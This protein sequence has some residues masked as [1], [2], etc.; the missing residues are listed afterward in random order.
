MVNLDALNEQFRRLLQRTDTS[1]VRSSME[2]IQWEARLIGIKGARG[3][4]KTTLMLQRIQL[5]LKEEI[6]ATLYVSLDSL[7]FSGSTIW[8]IAEEFVGRGGKYLFLDEVHK[9]EN[10]AQELK[11]VYDH[12][13]EL[14]VVFTSSSLLEILSSRADLSRRAVVFEMQGLSLREFIQLESGVSFPMLTLKQIIEQ[15]ESIAP[16]VTKKIKPLHYFRSYLESGYY[17]FYFEQKDLY[18]QKVRE[19]VSMILEIELPQLRGVDLNYLARL[20]QLLMI[21]AESVPFAP[22]VTKLSERIQ[23]DRKTL[24]S[25]LHFFAE[26]GLTTN[27][28]KE[29]QGVSRLQKPQ[30]IYLE[31]TNLMFAL[32]RSVPNEGSLREVFFANQL[33]FSH[34]VSYPAK[35]DFMIDE[36]HLFEVG[37]KSKMKK[38]IQGVDKAYLAVDG[39]EYGIDQRIPLWMFGFLY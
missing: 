5:H 38:Q 24:L 31:N 11:N 1:F 33:S 19:V 9:Y 15:H 16:E 3:V 4:G 17:P 39:I 18:E 37:G 10:W 25:Y 23:I 14:K 27:L 29:G 22:N 21:I 28:F 20:K 35:G 34:R 8:D 7:L 30:K 32:S 6:S 36:Q 26:A 12:F 13:P 2:L